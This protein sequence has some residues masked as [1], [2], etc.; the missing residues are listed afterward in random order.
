MSRTDDIINVAGHRLSTGGMEEILA[1]HPDV[2]EC[3]VL[4]V[5]DAIK[6]EVP[7]GFL[8]LKAGVKRAPAEIEKEIV[9]L[10]LSVPLAFLFAAE[11]WKRLML[12]GVIIAAELY[13][14]DL[15]H[16]IPWLS[17]GRLRPLHTNAVIFAFGGCALMATSFYCVQRT[18][19]VRLFSDK[20][21]GFVFWGWQAVIVLAA[22]TLPLGI[23][24]SKE[25]A[26]L[27]WPIDILITLVWVAY[28]VVFFGTIAK[29]KVKHIYVANWF[30]GA[31]I[32]AIALLV[33]LL[34]RQSVTAQ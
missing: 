28:A 11:A 3:A 6:G 17:Y 16:G 2:A 31:F 21:A 26:E 8:V 34:G 13:W 22:I 30:Y 18:C 23:T 27:E 25:Y 5:K 14:P 15:F 10:V 1:S 12:V 24:Q 19:E 4:G 7:C 9:A 20:L 33:R 32:V 29:R